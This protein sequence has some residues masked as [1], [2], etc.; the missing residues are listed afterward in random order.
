M[1]GW[2]FTSSRN[3]PSTPLLIVPAEVGP[4]GALAAQKLVR[5]QGDVLAGL[6][7]LVGISAGQTCSVMPSVY[8]AAKS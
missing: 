3:S 6:R 4:A 1:P 7:D 5:A 8:L 2:V